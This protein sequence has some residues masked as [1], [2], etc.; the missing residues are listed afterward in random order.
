MFTMP[1]ATE[2]DWPFWQQM[3]PHI[4]EQEW[5]LKLI[6]HRCHVL[7]WGHTPIGVLRYN[8]FWDAIPFL[9]ML[10][11][12]GDWRGKGLGRQAML[13]WENDMRSLHYRQTMT[14]TRS[15][16]QAQFF[17]RTLG[18]CDAGCLVLNLPGIEQPAELM[19]IKQL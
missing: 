19:L 2:K 6:A 1:Y 16:E 11:L 9:T 3:D 7:H 13:V 14:S 12:D 15:D 17:Y 4:P 5:R 18:Y 10:Y 8:L